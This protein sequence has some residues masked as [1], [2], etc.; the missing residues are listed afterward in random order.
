M[1]R[2]R[3]QEIPRKVLKSRNMHYSLAR[4]SQ[5]LLDSEGRWRVPHDLDDATVRATTIK[6]HVTCKECLKVLNEK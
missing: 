3:N 2:N 6:E 4:G 5:S 1:I